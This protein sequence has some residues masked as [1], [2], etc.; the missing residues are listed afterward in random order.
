MQ[1]SRTVERAGDNPNIDLILTRS[2]FHDLYRTLH[3]HAATE[4]RNVGLFLKLDP[5]QLD[6]IE[7]NK[8]CA[9]PTGKNALTMAQGD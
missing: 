8:Q 9:L 2:H 3:T 1:Q 4:W 7:T 6:V 5:T